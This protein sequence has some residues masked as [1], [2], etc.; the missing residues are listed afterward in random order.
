MEGQVRVPSIL[1]TPA[2]RTAE[3]RATRERRHNTASADFMVVILSAHSVV[4]SQR[5]AQV[6]RSR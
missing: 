3:E 5:G 1:E 2:R 4:K 6:A